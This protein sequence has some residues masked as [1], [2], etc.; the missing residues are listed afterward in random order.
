MLDV[1][2][3]GFVGM[4]HRELECFLA[5][6]RGIFGSSTGFGLEGRGYSSAVF[7]VLYFHGEET[8]L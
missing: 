4:G 7:V 1:L 2:V 8:A 6:W 3:K 5:A